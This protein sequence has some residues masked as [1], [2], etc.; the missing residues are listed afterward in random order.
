M[1]EWANQAL[2]A[3]QFIARVRAARE[4]SFSELEMEMLLGLPKGSYKTYET[5]RLLPHYLILRFCLFTGID[6]VE[7]FGGYAS[8]L[9]LGNGDGQK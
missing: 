6:M 8:A 2:F 9:H 7:L 1:V 4:E 3:A 5:H